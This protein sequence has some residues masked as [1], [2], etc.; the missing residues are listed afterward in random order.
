MEGDGAGN[1]QGATGAGDGGQKPT[2]SFI[3]TIT[4]EGLRGHESLKGFENLDSLAK[5]YIELRE[6]QPVIPESVDGYAIDV[7]QGITVNQA[8]LSSFKETA[9]KLKLTPDQYKGVMEFEFTR[10]ARINDDYNQTTDKNKKALQK[11]LGDN[12]DAA[13]Q[14]A[15]KVLEKA[16]GGKDLLNSVDLSNHPALFKLMTWIGEHISED[17]LETGGSASHGDTRP[18]DDAGNPQLKYASM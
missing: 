16:P 3:D 15:N 17:I 14:K 5:G 2:S 4:D 12:F 11:E 9:L 7:P 6:S 1:G 18:R 10:A 8:D 13:L